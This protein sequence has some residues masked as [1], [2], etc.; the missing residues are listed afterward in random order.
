MTLATDRRLTLDEFLAYDD[1]R[2]SRYELVD[3]VLKPMG[4]GT[5]KHGSVIQFLA[6]K[7]DREAERLGLGILA[8]QGNVGIQSPR[9]TRWD[10][11][12][13]PDITVLTA[14]LWDELQESEAIIRAG[15]GPALLVVE[16][17]SPSTAQTD[18]R[19]KHSEYSVLDIPE[20]WIV[21]LEQGLV[22]VCTLVEGRYEDVEF[23]EAEV[24]VSATF[25][26]L[27]LT[28]AEVLAGGR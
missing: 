22:T 2:N 9:G 26:E 24:I 7:F 20:Y 11:C 3:G 19:A 23:R 4:L 1:G 21:D 15:K 28:A 14:E 6:S 8:I 25:S 5:G 10:T 17:V 12:R 13:I 18:Y 27:G 16:V